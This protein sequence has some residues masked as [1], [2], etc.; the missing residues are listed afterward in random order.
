MEDLHKTAISVVSNDKP[1][2]A[3]LIATMI[4]SKKFIA[5]MAIIILAWM[6]F[7]VAAGMLRFDSYPF[8]FL[9]LLL[10]LMAAFTGPLVMMSQSKQ[11]DKDRK[12]VEY[13]VEINKK[14]EITLEDTLAE[15]RTLKVS[16]LELHADL[17]KLEHRNRRHV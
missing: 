14:T 7:N 2:V 11:E 8:V 10:G 3:D 13:D 6:A 5:V 4:S 1:D 15:I 12:L 9:N 16:I 17:Q